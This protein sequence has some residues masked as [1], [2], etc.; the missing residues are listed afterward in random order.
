MALTTSMIV[1][2][3]KSCEDFCFVVKPSPGNRSVDIV[4]QKFIPEI[5][6]MIFVS[7]VHTLVRFKYGKVVVYT[8]NGSVVE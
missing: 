1:V 6:D 5:D 4:S 2:S 8:P 3:H 7:N